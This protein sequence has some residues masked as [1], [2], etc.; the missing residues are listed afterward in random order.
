MSAA[1]PVAAQDRVA[2]LPAFL[3]RT[4]PQSSESGSVAAD[5]GRWITAAFCSDQPLEPEHCRD[6]VALDPSADDLFTYLCAGIQWRGRY[7]RLR[8]PMVALL[9]LALGGVAY[10][11]TTAPGKFRHCFDSCPLPESFYRSVLLSR[12]ALSR[13]PA[14]RYHAILFV[15]C[16]GRSAGI[17][18]CGRAGAAHLQWKL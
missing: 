14:A 6:S 1:A 15:D 9:L 18:V 12:R 10:L 3:S 16:S 4:L 5:G 2:K 11:I 17:D 8:W 13:R 7:S